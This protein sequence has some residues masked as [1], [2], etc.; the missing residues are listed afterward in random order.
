MGPL[1]IF[2]KFEI[3]CTFN[4]DFSSFLSNTGREEEEKGRGGR[5]RKRGGRKGKEKGRKEEERKDLASIVNVFYLSP[6]KCPVCVENPQWL[7]AC[8]HLLSIREE[9]LYNRDTEISQE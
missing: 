2:T 7:K 6:A 9:V 1:T 4:D 8:I 5:E 3:V